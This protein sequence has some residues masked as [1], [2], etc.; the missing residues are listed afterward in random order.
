MKKILIIM[1][2]AALVGAC[3][4]SADK[5]TA[6]TERE[7]PFLT[8]FATPFG[9]PPFEQILLDDYKPAYMQGIEEQ[10]KEIEAIIHATAAPDFE[11][12]IVALDQSGRLLAKV[13]AVFSG[14]NSAN[15]SDEMQAISREL[16]PILSAHR[17]D[18]N[19]NPDLFARVKT[20]YENL[21]ALN[22]N[23]E[24]AKLLEE[25]YKGFVR[26]GANLP[27]DKQARLRELNSEISL[28]QLT[29]SQNMLRETNAFQLIIENKDDLAGLPENLIAV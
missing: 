7:N 13:S 9:V 18:I 26:G 24:Q 19:L 16:S 23:K 15:T 2:L 25:T 3:N 6:E 11:N 4:M 20:V 22:L 12:T 27:A 14:Q 1:G 21:Q 28:L 29:F 10:K 5:K 8:E 17:D